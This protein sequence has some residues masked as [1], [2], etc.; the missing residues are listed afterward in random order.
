MHRCATP[1]GTG[2]PAWLRDLPWLLA[3]ALLPFGV[4]ASVAA[5]VQTLYFND[6]TELHVPIRA[7]FGNAWAE[8]R[9]PLWAPDIYLG[10]PLFAEGQ[11][12][13]L[14]PANWLLFATLPTW[15]AYGLSFVL[16]LSLAGVGTFQFLR[17]A[18]AR[19]AAFAGAWPSR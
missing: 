5:G 16:H 2:R 3:L 1:A 19:R 12:G 6:V 17:R 14:Y 8:G 18:I 9:F 7:F 11:A 10:F 13:P 15:W 4:H